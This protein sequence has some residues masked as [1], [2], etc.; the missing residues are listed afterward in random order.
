L[1]L[2]NAQFEM[3]AGLYNQLP[4]CDMPEVAFAGRSNV[5]KSSLIN[6][7]LKRKS[8]ARVSSQPGKTATI[9][10]YNIGGA[11]LVDLP[12][13]GFAKVSHSEKNRWR[14]L[15]EGYFNDERDLR[16]TVLLMDSRHKPS[17]DDLTML[18][19]LTEMKKETMIVLTKVDK[20]K[21]TKREE[22]LSEIEQCLSALDI[23]Q[24][25]TVVVASSETGEGVEDIREVLRLAVD[26][27][28]G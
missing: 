8:L 16:L 25:V 4:V 3:A 7:I 24:D 11:R 15:I 28:E 22:S 20:L 17:E 26:G 23:E 1:K 19:Y 2:E 14:E 27:E 5:G 6:K 9:N 10:F 18:R 21:P 13:Y 12:G